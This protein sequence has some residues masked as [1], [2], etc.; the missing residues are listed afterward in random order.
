MKDESLLNEDEDLKEL[1]D[2]FNKYEIELL[3]PEDKE[4]LGKSIYFKRNELR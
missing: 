3:E 1:F 4:L 2:E